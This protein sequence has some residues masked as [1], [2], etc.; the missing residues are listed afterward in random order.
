MWDDDGTKK[1]ICSPIKITQKSEICILTLNPTMLKSF[2]NF[3]P[4]E[5]TK[6][7]VK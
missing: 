1:I 4:K 3:P 5:M 7:N 6:E 2:P